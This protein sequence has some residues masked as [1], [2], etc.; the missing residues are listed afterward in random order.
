MPGSPDAAGSGALVPWGWVRAGLFLGTFAVLLSRAAGWA[1]WGFERLSG[2]RLEALGRDGSLEGRLVAMASFIGF[3]LCFSL[4]LAAAF[5]RIVDRR[6]LRSLGWTLRGQGK[7]IVGGLLTGSGILLTA[8]ALLL[9]ADH[10]DVVEVRVRPGVLG[11]YLVITLFVALQEEL[12]FRGYVLRNLL[13]SF[14]PLVALPLSAGLFLL[15]HVSGAGADPVMLA[16][17]LLGGLL[18]GMRYVFTL[19]LWFAVA[20]HC[21]WNFV[22]GPVLGFGVSGLPVVGVL[23]LELKGGS[24]WTGGGAGLEGSMLLTGLLAAAVVTV[25]MHARRQH[26]CAVRT[27]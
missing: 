8:F 25:G 16:N 5:C 22:E 23:G 2:V 21:S 7:E 10:V 6:G 20:L 12:V 14:P 1:G 19:N 17:A 24:R 11:A 26:A 18:L 9:A 3:T 13:D 4:V 15:I 27:G